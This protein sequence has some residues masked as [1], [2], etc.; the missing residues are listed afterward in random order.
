MDI[1]WVQLAKEWSLVLG[2][3]VIFLIL[4]RGMLK[5]SPPPSHL[6]SAPSQPA[7]PAAPPP[8]PRQGNYAEITAAISAAVNEYRKTN[9]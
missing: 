8:P 7:R 2:F 6:D 4:I 9:K 3:A 5:N 1:D